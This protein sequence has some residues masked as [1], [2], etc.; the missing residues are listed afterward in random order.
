MR[1]ESVAKI[2]KNTPI[3]YVGLP[4]S[5]WA[6]VFNDAQVAQ[7]AQL[8]AANCH[9]VVFNDGSTV[10]IAAC[11]KTDANPDI[12]TEN[13]R[14][15]GAEITKELNR[16]K[17][18]KAG[19]HN[20]DGNETASLAVAEGAF[21]AGYQ[22]T[23]YISDKKR[24]N[25]LQTIEVPTNM[26]SA[27]AITELSHVL[28]AVCN[29]RDLVNEPVIT[30]TAPKLADEIARLGKAAGVKVTIFDKA[31]ITKE[32]MGGI[33][34]VNAGSIDEPRFTIMEYKPKN[35]K[36]K[37]PIVLVGKGVVYD[38]GGL[39]L[40]PSDGMEWMKCDMGG[41]AA[42]ACAICAA[43]HNQLPLHIVGL[44]PS[45]D[46]RPGGNA[47]TPGDVITHY[48][49]TTCEVLNTDA[50]GRLILADALAY[51]KQYKPELVIDIATL[52]GAAVIAVGHQGMLLM[53]NDAATN[54]KQQITA[55]S[56]EVYERL[57]E[58]PLW[59]EFKEQLKSDIADLKNIGG[60]PAGSIT[61]AKF[62]E[63][64]T[65]YPWMHVDM[66]PTGWAEKAHGYFTAHG[67]GMGV[68]LF[69]QF[70]KQRANNS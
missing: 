11:V 51:A 9:Q 26:A 1:I 23:R 61:A 27:A 43:A 60:R 53:G 8:N 66:A 28:T 64:F 50:E 5:N 30:L 16:L 48:G 3:V 39:S 35:A 12:Q 14:L 67:T 49:G 24:F 45:T 38:T 10:A 44:I 29:A 54:Y 4:N 21:L 41:A 56:Y 58:L 15:A 59:G 40:K 70:L 65:D 7:I 52:T 68:R 33:L 18:N 19:I 36:N 32:K 2:S 55:C 22:F 37:Q 25:T 13:Y 63:H 42:V 62:L 17:I 20:V 47:Y 6:K 46:N 69:Y 57:A 34:A 31:R